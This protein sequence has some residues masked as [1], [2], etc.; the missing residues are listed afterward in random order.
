MKK[1][2]ECDVNNYSNQVALHN[3]T[4]YL[5]KYEKWMNLIQEK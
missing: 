2:N 1:M 3:H 4:Y 5:I